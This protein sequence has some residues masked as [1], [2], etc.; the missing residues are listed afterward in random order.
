[1][2]TKHE[3]PKAA[4]LIEGVSEVRIYPTGVSVDG[5]LILSENPSASSVGREW[6]T[7]HLASR[8]K[9]LIFVEMRGDCAVFRL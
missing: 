5:S 9:S 1:M 8:N 4:L 3:I 2:E 6:R 7:A